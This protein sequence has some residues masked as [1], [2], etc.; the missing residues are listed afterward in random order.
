MYKPAPI[1]GPHWLDPIIAEQQA[2]HA[3]AGITPEMF[4][5]AADF[6]EED[7]TLINK[8]AGKA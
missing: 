5:A 4:E 1:I 7:E 2:S 8:K 3:A 6:T